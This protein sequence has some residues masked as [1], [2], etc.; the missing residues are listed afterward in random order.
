GAAERGGAS[1]GAEEAVVRPEPSRLITYL[2]EDLG[3]IEKPAG[4]VVHSA[5]SHSGETL[6]DLLGEILGG[7]EAGRPGIVH[8]LDKNTSGL[9]IVARNEESHRALA[10]MVKAR[11]IEREYTALVEG[12]LGSRTGTI[13]PPLAPDPRPP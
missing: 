5:P 12:R 9:M 6:V 3:V 11:R 2:D 10:R 8:R 13:D 4:L 1:G 7:G